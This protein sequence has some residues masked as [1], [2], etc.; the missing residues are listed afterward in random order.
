LG[1]CPLFFLLGFSGRF[2]DL[3][4]LL[5]RGDRRAVRRNL[6]ER[7]RKVRETPLDWSLI[8]NPSIHDI[9]HGKAKQT[10]LTFLFPP[11]IPIEKQIQ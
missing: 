7:T 3:A 1:R 4:L 10:R 8:V 9:P 11:Q 6:E 2:G 5:L